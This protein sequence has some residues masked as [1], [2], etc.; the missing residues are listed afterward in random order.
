MSMLYQI[1]LNSLTFP[2]RKQL[3][4]PTPLFKHHANVILHIVLTATVYCLNGLFGAIR[5]S[6]HKCT[7]SFLAWIFYYY[8]HIMHLK[9][10]MHP[11]ANK[12][13]QWEINNAASTDWCSYT[14]RRA[15][16]IGK[17]PNR[18]RQ[19]T[20]WYLRVLWGSISGFSA[21]PAGRGTRDSSA[22][23]S[24]LV[25]GRREEVLAA[26]SIMLSLWR[27]CRLPARR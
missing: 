12:T 1:I 17:K 25:S 15:P 22:S 16:P 24:L 6:G 5:V 23:V 27:R 14:C 11:Q 3:P 13:S 8:L 9:P 4:E 21:P 26:V 18:S 7:R 19:I 20:Q 2:G 10:P